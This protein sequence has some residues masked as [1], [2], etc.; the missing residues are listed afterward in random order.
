MT[1]NR[2]DFRLYM[3]QRLSALLMVP[4]VLVHLGVMIYA[5]RGGL[6]AAEILGRT[7]GSL[8]WFAFYGTFVVAVSVHTALGLRAILGEWAGLRGKARDGLSV[9]IA[10]MLLALGARA[11]WAVTMGGSL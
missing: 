7:Q 2:F 11:I 3:L 6:S 10:L 9:V 5:I 4:F 8:A 1:D